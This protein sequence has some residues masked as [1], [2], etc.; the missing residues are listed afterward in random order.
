MSDSEED[1]QYVTLHYYLTD[2][3]YDPKRSGGLGGVE[4]LY[5]D[6]KKE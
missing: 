4:Q 2:V 3:Y 5:N 1:I 6:V